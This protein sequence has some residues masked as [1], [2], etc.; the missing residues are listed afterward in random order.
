MKLDL[1]VITAAVLLSTAPAFAHANI[2]SAIPADQ[3]SGP[4]PRTLELSFTEVLNLTFSGAK[5]IGPDGK[6]VEVG[7]PAALGDGTGMTLPV[8][9]T[10]PPGAYI[11]EW[12][13]LSVDGHKLNGTYGFTVTP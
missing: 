5:L 6:A 4:A 11:V 12:N 3:S 7:K 1:L 8:V 13:V 10:V 2:T 9:G